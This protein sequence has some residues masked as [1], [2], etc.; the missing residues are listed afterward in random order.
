MTKQDYYKLILD[1]VDKSLDIQFECIDTLDTKISILIGTIAIVM[2]FIFTG[3]LDKTNIYYFLSFVTLSASFILA[4]IAYSPKTF[5][6]E[7]ESEKLLKRLEN[8][9]DDEEKLFKDLIRE[10]TLARVKNEERVKL[11]GQCIRYSAILLFSGLIVL[12][13]SIFI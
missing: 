11:K 3:N 12:S 9:D 8:K 4:I 10:K 13:F 6:W 7:I 1:Q 2:S 5:E